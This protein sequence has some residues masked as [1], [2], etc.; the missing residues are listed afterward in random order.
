MPARHAPPDPLEDLLLRMEELR[1]DVA[2]EGRQIYRGWR[3]LIER[4]PFR[5][6]ALNFAHYLALR[7]RDLRDLQVQL[8]PYGL[9]SLGRLEARVLANLD[10]VLLA[11][12]A[13]IG[14]RPAH[15][16][17]PR[18][19]FRGDALLEA[20]AT[21]LLGPE[22]A[23][24][25]VR[26]MVTLGAD[27]AADPA[28]A[29][30]L[31]KAGTDAVRINCAHDTPAEWTAMARNVR[32]AAARARR[33]VPILMDL[34]GP[35]VRIDRVR[36]H[37]DRN[38]LQRGD[39]FLI[40]AGGHGPRDVVSVTCSITSIIGRL[41]VGDP[42]FVDDGKL[43]GQVE[44]ITDEGAEI[45]V[46]HAPKGGAKLK[47]DQGLNFPNTDLQLPA[48]TDDDRRDLETV[49]GCADIVGYSFVQS[50]HDIEV[51]QDELRRLRPADWNRLGL[52]AKI[53]TPLA[54]RN[55]PEIIVRA[56]SRQPFGVMIARGDLAVELG[57]ERLAEMQ[58]EILWLC[59]AAQVP[60]IWATQVLESLIKRGLP[61]R[62]DMT[63]AAMSARA[64]CVMLNK[65]P[66]VVEAVLLLDRLLVTMA[67]HQSKKTSR[68]RA[69]RSW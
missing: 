15:Y 23:G 3:P 44:R 51:L 36:H 16:P 10:A 22:R 17:R 31:I 43:A 53:E 55:L 39:R 61:T 19:F 11:L 35:K 20:H 45:R 7:R 33:K 26:I 18:A 63:D 8:M 50:A 6:S 41:A 42:A 38:P 66:H 64:E 48:L 28:I 59:E 32:K 2:R 34:G 54:V 4:T 12:R 69:L 60:V 25:K 47:A 58:E 49:A 46:T 37:G 14:D 65:G 57:F 40:I 1:A 56:A 67:E 62:G 30:A 9:S 5:L 21:D 29:T 13:I 27:A 68:L 52:L 24:R